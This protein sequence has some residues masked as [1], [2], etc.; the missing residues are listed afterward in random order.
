MAKTALVSFVLGAA[1]TAAA[2]MLNPTPEQHRARMKEAFAQS[3]PLA[4]T[5]GVGAI[6]AFASTYH[7]LGVASYTTANDRLRS[8]G[9][10]GMVLVLPYVVTPK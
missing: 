1:V 3:S 7:T 8:I 9:A 10:L 6:A 2:F 5:L 4:G